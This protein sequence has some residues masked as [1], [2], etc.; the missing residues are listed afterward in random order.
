MSY[1][2][3]LPDT[4]AQPQPDA[5]V[6]T[7]SDVPASASQLPSVSAGPYLSYPPLPPVGDIP[8]SQRRPL[9]G[10]VPPASAVADNKSPWKAATGPI[11]KVSNKLEDLIATVSRPLKPHVPRFGR[12]LLVATF[13]EDALR[14]ISQWDDQLEYLDED[15]HH[16]KGFGLGFL[17][18]NVALMI[19]CSILVIIKRWSWFSFPGLIS[20][21]LA[22][23]IVYDLFTDVTFLCLNVSLLGG[24][25]LGLSDTL[26]VS[27]PVR[28]FAGLPEI[29]ENEK[30]TKRTYLQLAG[31]I[32]I[33]G[34][35][36]GQMILAWLRLSLAV[37]P[38]RIFLAVLALIACI[39]VAVG[40]K[41]RSSALFLVIISASINVMS[42]NWWSK[43]K[44][45]P[46]RDFRKYDFFQV[47]SIV[48]GLILLINQGPGG[49]SVDAKRKVL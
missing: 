49:I 21:M 16:S 14:I 34:F 38:L 6:L 43:P 7:N 12:F 11:A 29:N 31:R 48:G 39:L 26:D 41:A 27:A 5:P 47:L 24:L 23:G 15:Q 32:L 20:V 30:S 42:N 8:S 4:A 18:S 2:A 17:I 37:T 22:Q 10:Y 9:T 33:V 13:L 45:H 28:A 35:F 1:S 40:F 46:E 3:V 36:I 19:I 25:L 44:D